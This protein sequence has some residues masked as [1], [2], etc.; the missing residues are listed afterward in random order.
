MRANVR[1][2]QGVKNKFA[3]Q[4]NSGFFLEKQHS[5]LFVRGVYGLM[6]KQPS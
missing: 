2:L 1:V 4:T 5:A 3:L 6:L